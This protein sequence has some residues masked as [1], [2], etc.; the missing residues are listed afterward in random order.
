MSSDSGYEATSLNPESSLGATYLG[1]GKCRFLV[2][3]PLAQKVVVHLVAPGEQFV[4]LERDDS[5][6]HRGQAECVQEGSVYFYRLDDRK[7]RADPASRYQPEG[8]HGPSQVMDPSFPWRDAGWCGLPLQDY[9]IYELHVGAFTPEGS[10]EAIIP[11]LDDLT[12]LGITAIELMPLAQFPGSRNWGYDGAYPFAVQNSYGGPTGLKRLVDACHERGVAVVLD[13][14]YNHLGPEGNFLADYA[15]YFTDRY[16]TPWGPGIN[17]DGSG[18]AGVRRFFHENA[19]R[20]IS[21]YHVDALRLDSVHDI[22]DRSAEPFLMELGTKVREEALRLERHVHLIAES[23]VND[24][25]LIRPRD[26]GGY[27][28][29]AQWN[30]DFHHS[31]HA[32]LTGEQTGY[33]EDFGS[34]SHLVKALREG[35]VYRGVF[36]PDSHH[37]NEA[38]SGDVPAHR[39]VVFAQNHDQVGNR[40]LGE[41]LSQLVS[42]EALKLAAGLVLLS[43]FVPLLFMGEEYGETAPFQYFISHSNPELVEAVRKGR[44]EEFADFQWHG[45]PP[46]PQDEAVYLRS[47]LNHDLRGEGHHRVLLDFYGELIRL[48]KDTPPLSNPSKDAMQVSGQEDIKVVL[49][50]RWSDG[51]EAAVIFHF[52]KSTTLATVL[53]PAGVWHK[54]IDASEERW[55][56][57]GS[58]IPP[59]MTSN[60]QVS[61][62]LSPETFV[63]FVHSKEA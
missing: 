1:D 27:G 49:V 10:L 31:L 35:F 33:Y 63:L 17:F 54:R 43:P 16:H 51:G 41:R 48:R 37:Q 25:V 4:A 19:L 47:K 8:V 21:E 12:Q 53:L 59:T 11:H 6:Y 34:I 29:D 26:Q 13:V 24:A 52:G 5:G 28:L 57:P 45:D 61:L 23:A 62:S 50:R 44:M 60:G 15:P 58:S 7:E 32:L 38:T 3:A 2:W 22:K 39:L 18:S 55:H 20:W 40:L 30:E 14:V 46:D 9:T 56:G 42:F 36:C